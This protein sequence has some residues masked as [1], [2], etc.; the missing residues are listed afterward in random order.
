VPAAYIGTALSKSA[1]AD[2]TL[3][4]SPAPSIISCSNRSQSA[5]GSSS[6]RSRCSAAIRASTG[7]YIFLFDDDVIIPNGVIE[8]ALETFERNPDVQVVGGPNL[9]PPENDYIQHCFGFAHG[10]PFVGLHTAARYRAAK[11]IGKITEKHLISCN[12]AFRSKV[13][14]ENPFDPKIFPNEENELIARISG[15]DNLLAYN[16]DFFVYHHRRKNLA[17]YIKQIFNWGRGRT[18]HSVKKPKNFD[19]VFFVPMLFLFYLASLVWI[20]NAWYSLP[21]SM[22]IIL[23]FIFT[24]E[25]AVSFKSFE[26]MAMMFWL[27]PLTHITY[28]LGLF[29]GFFSFWKDGEK[30]LPEEKEFLLIKIEMP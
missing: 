23:D 22:Y 7:G 18:L 27:F 14:K 10:S 25:T 29:A 5:T 1:G 30:E 9:T 12:L 28:A 13:L 6:D 20:H 4:Y 16:P 26:S 17:A 8:K 15:K 2:G 21:L 3:I 11:K 19:A 24:V